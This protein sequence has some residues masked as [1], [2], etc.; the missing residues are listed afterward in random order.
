M[1]ILR[2]VQDKSNFSD[3]DTINPSNLEDILAFYSATRP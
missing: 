1:G 2:L 3:E